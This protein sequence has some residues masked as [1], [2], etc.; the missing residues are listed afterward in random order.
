MLR[1]ILSLLLLLPA[2]LRA[3]DLNR[4]VLEQI[5]TV[6]RGGGYAV[7]STAS[8]RLRQS[9]SVDRGHLLVA[10][11]IARPSYCSGATYLVLLKTLTALEAQG[12]LT[13]SPATVNA[14]QI[15]GQP[16]G[17]GLWGRWNAN[18]PGTP[19]LFHELKLGRNFESYAEA[20]PGDFMKI[21]WTR[22]VGQKEH[23]HSVI[24]LGEETI[25]GEPGVRFWSSN[26]PDGY[27]AKVVPKKKIAWAVFSRLEHPERINGAAKLPD[28]D[29]YLA[30]LLKVR[31][32][33]KEVREKSGMPAAR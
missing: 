23:G 17:H 12:R 11:Q 19:R 26:Q 32:S 6:P 8:Q 31:S 10:P 20:R 27:G 16:D 1:V 22:E 33:A 2:M 3:E 21:F 14:L 18:G 30:S 5:R 7:T 15:K 25:D 29:A 28:K 4:L 9:V 13:L 24:F